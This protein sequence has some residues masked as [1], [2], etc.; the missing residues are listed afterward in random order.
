MV[1]IGMCVRNCEPFIKD[2]IESVLSQD[3][4]QELMEIIFVDDGSTDGSLS[5]IKDYAEKVN[6]P[7]KIFH[8]SWR[9]IGFCRNIV[10]KN[11]TG[12]YI[13]W[14]DGDMLI[15]KNFVTKLVE[16]M[17]HNSAVGVAKGKQALVC[18][19]NKL[20][21]LE[22]Y[23]RAAS[24]MVDYQSKKAWFK[25]LGTGGSIYRVDAIRE[26]GGFDE[27]LRGYGEDFDAEL[28][29]R[30]AG[31]RLSTVNVEFLD[32][33][34]FNITWNML[35]KRYWIRGFY[36]RYL[37]QKNRHAVIIYKMLPPVAAVAGVLHAIKLYKITRQKLVF[38]LPFMYF[39]KMA[40]WLTG[41]ISNVRY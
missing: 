31:W 22:T 37:L 30:A 27:D 13:V 15:P 24:R 38:F 16:Y 14:V 6:F 2:A 17:E 21:T 1:T 26:V 40:A 20:G 32:Y 10:V 8:T 39:F 34:R 28:R 5:I 41:F 29:L 19:A 33:E 25:S 23:S 11:A 9:G 7:F 35:W 18:G 4:P 12:K 36:T 3:F